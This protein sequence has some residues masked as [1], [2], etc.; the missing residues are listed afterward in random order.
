VPSP[1]WLYRLERALH[2]ELEAVAGGIVNGTPHSL[3][4]TAEYLLSC[5]EAF[6]RRP[7]PIRHGPG[8]NLLVRRGYFDA[9]RNPA[10]RTAPLGQQSRAVASANS[11]TLAFCRWFRDAAPGLGCPSRGR[12]RSSGRW[13]VFAVLAAASISSSGWRVG[14]GF[15]FSLEDSRVRAGSVSGCSSLGDDQ[16]EDRMRRVGLAGW[17]VGRV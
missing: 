12:E 16:W 10:S 7:R 17:S 11:R 5:S 4:G 2:P 6:P 14:V 9:L 1:D 13:R 8:A 3:I 15:A